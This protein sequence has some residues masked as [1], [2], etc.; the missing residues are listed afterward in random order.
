MTPHSNDP[1]SRTTRLRGHRVKGANTNGSVKMPAMLRYRGPIQTDRISAMR[2]LSASKT[3]G[4]ASCGRNPESSLGAFATASFARQRSNALQRASYRRAK[5]QRGWGCS[6]PDA[7]S[8]GP[9]ERP[10][11]ITILA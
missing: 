2:P 6:P 5:S 10:G 1:I 9:P 3:I 7:D 8:T 11:H 4:P